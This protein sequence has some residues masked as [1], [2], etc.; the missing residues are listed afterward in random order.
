MIRSRGGQL[1]VLMVALL[2]GGLA[3]GLVQAQEG[4]LLGN[5]GFE[6]HYRSYSF[7]ETDPDTVLEFRIAD[8]WNPWF[9]QQGEGERN[10]YYRRPEYRPG[11]YSYNGTM[12]QQFFTSFSTHEAGFFQRVPDRLIPGEV[13]RF[14]IA[15]YIW[16]S[17]GGD[18]YRS[19]NPGDVKIRIGID[20]LGETNP[21]SED[22]VWSPFY[23]FYDEWQVLSVE[24]EA[25]SPSATVFVWSGQAYPVMHNDSAWDEAF[26]GL[27]SSAPVVEAAAGELAVEGDA[28]PVAEAEPAPSEEPTAEEA[29]PSDEAESPD[30]V[31][32]PAEVTPV[33]VSAY[34]LS[35]TTVTADLDLKLRTRKYADVLAVIPAGTVIEVYGRSADQDWAFV[36]YNGQQGW[37]ASWYGRY[38]SPYAA[39]PEIP[40]P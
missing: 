34:P 16:S 29:A 24:A 17:V 26:F 11:T 28:E 15:A 21:W 1:I 23:T 27:A 25:Q 8:G 39:L 36:E 19:E 5:S 6:G 31:V 4:N 2:L 14:N 20:P 3:V 37:V 22:I 32:E 10:D 40:M 12:A 38:S 9:R 13:Y 35:G 18:F 7:G 30:A 33:T